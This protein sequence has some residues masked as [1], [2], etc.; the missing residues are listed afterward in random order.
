ML[1]IAKKD[2]DYLLVFLEYN[3][4]TVPQ[5]RNVSI[6][7]LNINKY[8]RFC[9]IKYLGSRI[10]ILFTDMIQVY[11]S[12]PLMKLVKQ[13]NIADANTESPSM[14]LSNNLLVYC[15]IRTCAL[16]NMTDDFNEMQ[17]ITFDSL[18][19]DVA[20]QYPYLF[21]VHEATLIQYDVEV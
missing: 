16:H 11:S 4:S 8:S 6:N 15:I 2:R 3:K 12:Y 18:V 7:K 9:S 5:Y 10:I 14:A 1:V 20:M 21:I 13:I 19:V 17:R